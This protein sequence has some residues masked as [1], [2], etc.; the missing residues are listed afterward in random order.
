ML[1][2]AFSK[3]ACPGLV[4]LKKTGR[5]IKILTLFLLAGF[6]QLSA[7]TY[8]QGISFSLKDA[9]ITTAFK[10]IQEQTAYRFVYASEE[11][12]SAVK[13]SCTVENAS[14]DKVLEICFKDQ[15]LSY[16]IED[17]F[18]LVKGKEKKMIA[19]IVNEIRGTVTNEKGEP[20]Q[21][22]SIKVKG[23]KRGTATDA[24]GMFVLADINA[25]S[26]LVISSIGYETIEL[27]T[28]KLTDIKIRLQ[29]TVNGLDEMVIKGYYSTSKRLNTGSVSKITAED[30]GKQS[31]S[32]PLAAMEGRIPGLY[33]QQGSGI[34]G[35][36][37]TVRIRG[38]NSIAN[39]NNPLYII[40]GVPFT[41]NSL[42]NPFISGNI[43]G[44]GNPLSE[45]NPMDIESI[46][47]LKDAD[48]TAIYGSRGANGII[49]ITTKKG[50]AGNTK[51]D[52]NVNAGFGNVRRN[53]KLLN[54]TQYLMMRHEAFKNDA[55]L[56]DP[57][58]DHDILSWD[59]SRNTDWQKTL[60]GGAAHFSNVQLS[61]SGGTPNT[62]FLIAGNY[63]YEST[64]FPGD[65]KDKKG[66]AHFNINHK[67]EN[68]KFKLLLSGSYTSDNN[69][70]FGYDLTPVALLLPPDAPPVYQA[71][72][73]LNWEKGTYTN[74]L[75]NTKQKYISTT[76]NLIANTVF[77]YQLTPQ[78]DVKANLG[79]TKMSISEIQTNPISV[80]NPYSGYTAANTF[81]YFGNSS[82]K[83][84]ILEPQI[85]WH[86]VYKNSK[87]DVLTGVTFQEDL[88]EGQTLQATGFANESLMQNIG[89]SNSIRPISSNFNQYRYNAIFGRINY[90][91]KEKLLFNA[92]AR[93]DGS[94]RFGPGKQF[95][96]FAALGTAWIFS[97]SAF[98]QNNFSS[99]SF[100]KLR[101]SY[102][103]TGNDQ[104][105]DYQYL[106]SW[107]STPYTYQGVSGLSPLRLFNS[108]YAWELNRK[109]EMAL[110]LGFIKDRVLLS[111][112]YFNN[113]SE[114]QLVGFP[115]APSTGFSS[116]QGNL[117]ARVRNTGFEIVINSINVKTAS[118]SWS[119]G[120]NITIPRN[121]LLAFPN[122]K[123]SPY[124]TVYSIGRPLT[125]VQ[126]LQ[127]TGVD[128]LT[129]L[130]GFTDI[131]K[132][133][134]IS[135]PND[136]QSL[137][138][139]NQSYYGGLQNTLRLKQ[140]QLDFLFQFV[141]Q[142]GYN[143]M[144]LFLNP[145]GFY[146]NQPSLVLNRWQKPGD[147]TGVQ[148]FSQAY[149]DAYL[150]YLYSY[151]FGDNTISDA[152]FIRLKNVSLSYNLPDK[153]RNKLH[154]NEARLFIQGQNLLTFTNYQGLDPET[155]GTTLP[156][157][158]MLTGG[159]HF[160]F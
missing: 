3:K 109:F 31:V 13:I 48:A 82:L 5:M 18:I 29:I 24:D 14:I 146:G 96:N 156:P 20:I 12:V 132:D 25:G 34:P 38:Q 67:S 49:L 131:D 121:K 115:L 59:T 150:Q 21:G 89:S 100:G 91:W 117:P 147:H 81:S 116:V 158:R 23:V 75:S 123:G 4:A 130:Y 95:A 55:A 125:I 88:Q 107:G 83:T 70:L 99:L 140:W 37:Y 36:S 143:Y 112:A 73:S 137:K 1:L 97:K 9:P 6:L 102:G 44:G 124:E 68:G 35:S 142:T 90:A 74:P 86:R 160:T 17:K 77:G 52:L 46:E 32:N 7:K 61:A 145:P 129:G 45:I 111:A 136:L 22:A 119:T 53:L 26:I 27:S 71:D 133:G 10:K 94:S 65:F 54:T 60:F 98:I 122:L 154:V 11:I 93:R 80:F 85:N 15:P 105:G 50:K 64:V 62:Q 108:N 79:Y 120:F 114:N 127:S 135:I 155:L 2:T 76:D 56:P 66:S 118:F 103:T 57:S 40:D 106:N 19:P 8:S 157:L 110:E 42:S 139:I 92:T 113:K 151:Y 69:N 84:W 28:G 128:P 51:I 43:T 39:G 159:F 41:S 87:W 47:V 16:S 148:Q 58:Y 30:I 138:S 153:I 141:K 144:K 152:S 149:G 63:N 101:A 134:Q 72:G 33:I 126:A 104:I 78:L